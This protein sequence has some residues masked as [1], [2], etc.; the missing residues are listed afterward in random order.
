M[1]EG[2]VQS[3]GGLS[4][5]SKLPELFVVGT[6]LMYFDLELQDDPI[7]IGIASDGWNRDRV[8]RLEVFDIVGGEGLDGPLSFAMNGCLQQSASVQTERCLR[9]RASD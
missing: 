3:K 9:S 5:R 1:C 8:F 6:E 4:T 2:I 7:G